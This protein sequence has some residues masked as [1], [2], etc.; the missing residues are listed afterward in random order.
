M[1]FTRKHVKH[2]DAVRL[3]VLGQ[4]KIDHAYRNHKKPG[5]AIL[6]SHEVDFRTR[7]ITRCKET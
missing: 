3:K 1:L 2:K 4:K 6:I 7:N 5:V